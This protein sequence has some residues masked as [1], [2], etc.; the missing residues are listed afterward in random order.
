MIYDYN[1]TSGWSI[2]SSVTTID[3]QA[4]LSSAGTFYGESGSAAESFAE[5]DS[6]R[7]FTS[8]DEDGS[9]KFTISAGENGYIQPNGTYTLPSG[10]LDGK[11]SVTLNIV[12]DYQYKIASLMV[13]GEEVTEAVGQNEYDLDY[14]FTTDSKSIE[15]TFE[16]DPDDSETL[17]KYPVLMTMRLLR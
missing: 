11:H 4:F 16:E 17:R 3:D 1:T 7:D 8:Y 14:T 5:G 9:V 10:M 2:P 15:V 6:T 12:S 13:D